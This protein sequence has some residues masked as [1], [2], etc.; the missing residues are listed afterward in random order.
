MSYI[1]PHE[2][3]K[4]LFTERVSALEKEW[5]TYKQRKAKGFWLL[6]KPPSYVLFRVYTD[7]SPFTD[8]AQAASVF[9]QLFYKN[10]RPAEV[11][12][13]QM[14]HGRHSYLVFYF[15]NWAF[16]FNGNALMQNK[17][18]LVRLVSTSQ[19]KVP[20]HIQLVA[21]YRSKGLLFSRFTL[22]AADNGELWVCKAVAYVRRK[23]AP[24][25]FRREKLKERVLF[26]TFKQNCCS[27]Y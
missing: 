21:R 27:F 15:Q 5:A 23:N 19:I 10:V 6:K 9:S 26:K 4:V 24:F 16:L 3:D 17:A 13:G 8:R 25:V 11:C 20:E 22:Q 18:L 2:Q 14:K 1:I 7:M 12:I